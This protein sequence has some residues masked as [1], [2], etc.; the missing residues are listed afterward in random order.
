VEKYSIMLN[1][2]RKKQLIT[3]LEINKVVRVIEQYYKKLNSSFNANSFFK[4]LLK[5]YEFANT[6]MYNSK[7]VKF[8]YGVALKDIFELFTLSPA[9]ADYK[10]ENFLWDLGRLCINNNIIDNYQIEL[11]CSRDVKKMYVIKTANGD[12][13]KASTLTLHLVTDNE[14]N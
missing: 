4:R 7:T 2:G 11:G 1:M 10:L 5:A 9:S 6:R 3:D 14:N 8:G 12:T 13:L